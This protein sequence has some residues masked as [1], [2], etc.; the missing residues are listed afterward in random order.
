MI[1]YLGFVNI[2]KTVVIYKA[3]DVREVSKELFLPVKGLVAPNE[4]N[5][6][7]TSSISDPEKKLAGNA[8]QEN[9]WK[10][11]TFSK[12]VSLPL[13]GKVCRGLTEIHMV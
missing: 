9:S 11:H 5:V 3:L 10:C 4:D 7:I 6:R 2:R 1:K 12:N 8:I 13:C